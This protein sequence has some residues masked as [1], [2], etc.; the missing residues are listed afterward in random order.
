[1]RVFLAGGVP[2]VMLHLRRLGLIDG[3]ALT[4]VGK[5]LDEV[6]DEWEGSERRKVVRARLLEAD[7]VDPD[8]VICPTERAKEKGLTSTISY[9]KGNLAP[10][11]AIVKST[12]I[13]RTAFGADGVFRLTGPA[14]VFT[15]ERATSPAR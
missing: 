12:A 1:V 7:G 2:E 15:T 6:L 5:T 4:A 13:A 3:K 14:R 11:G 10:Q 9:I 8:E